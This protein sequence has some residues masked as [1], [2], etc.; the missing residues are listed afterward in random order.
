MVPEAADSLRQVLDQVFASGAYTWTDPVVGP[1]PAWVRWLGAAIRWLVGLWNR[2]TSATRAFSTPLLWLFLALGALLLV[3]AAFRLAAAARRERDA[4]A[5]GPG[6]PAVR[7]DAEWFRTRSAE[8]AAAGRYGE[9]MVAAFH[10][11]MLGL[12][13]RG[14]ARYHPGRTPAEL[15]RTARLADAPLRTL[16]GLVAELYRAA[17]G[18]EEVSPARYREWRAELDEATGATAH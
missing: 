2:L 8:L 17:F 18:G 15:A 6:R 10:A 4:E 11:A 3:H 12:D 16:R 14:A 7:R 5:Q 1:V 9:A 13:R